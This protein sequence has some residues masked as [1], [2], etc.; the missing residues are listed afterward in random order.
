MN[1]FT[2]IELRTGVPTVKALE[3]L[4]E[5]VCG[6]GRKSQSNIMR[7]PKIDLEKFAEFRRRELEVSLDGADSHSS[8]GADRVTNL[9]LKNMSELGKQFLLDVMNGVVRTGVV[10]K[11]GM[12]RN[13]T[14]CLPTG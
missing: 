6:Y 4:L 14:T 5:T 9:D 2:D 8:P 1:Q 7:S 11:S 12:E 3:T 13:G 10:L